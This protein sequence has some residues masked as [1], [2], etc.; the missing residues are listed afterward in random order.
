M[1]VDGA[2]VSL[3]IKKKKEFTSAI[4]PHLC[5]QREKWNLGWMVLIPSLLWF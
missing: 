5:L 3:Q 2:T 4:Q 1:E